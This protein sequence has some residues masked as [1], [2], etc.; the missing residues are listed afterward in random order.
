MACG[1]SFTIATA[2]RA[3][4]AP[5]AEH[6]VIVIWDGLR[7]DSVNEHDTP[8]LFKLAA[9]GTTFTN[10]HCVY[11]SSTEVNG[12]ALATG[13]YPHSTGI[14][15][16]SEF[17]PDIDPLKPF[18]TESEAAVRNG[19]EL[20]RGHYLGL[21]TVAE[22]IQ[23]NGGRTVVAGTKPVAL[24]ADRSERSEGSMSPMLYQGRTLPR[25]L[26]TMLAKSYGE[27]PKAAN[28]KVAAN[29]AADAWTTRSLTESL[30]A[31]GVPQ[32]SVLWLSEPDYAQHGSGPNSAVARDALK[33][34]DQ[35]LARVLEA[36]D[37][38][39]ARETTAVFVVS[40]HGFSTIG[41]SIDTAALLNDAG[42]HAF[43]TLPESPVT[44]S[45]VVVA[46]GG[47]VGLYVV[48]RDKRTIQRLVDFFEQSDFAGVIF[49]RFTIEG[50]FPLSAAE[51]DTPAAPDIVVALRWSAD[52]SKTGLPGMIACDSSK[53][54]V[55]QGMHATLSRFDM[56]NTL[57]A[58]G[59]GIRSRYKDEL[60][61]GNADVAPTVLALLG[62]TP[63]AEMDGRPLDEALAQRAAPAESPVIETLKATHRGDKTEW[64]QYLRRTKLGRQIYLDEGNGEATPVEKR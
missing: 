23:R 4:E 37:R 30:W 56:H 45:V 5:R 42:F 26:A 24:L 39:K 62:I 61:S 11:V 3:A 33:S 32:F 50:T 64:N 38:A 25:S 47:T 27:F 17:R 49:C 29:R 43:H 1:V 14:M 52:K 40:D 54:V 21:P 44:G 13:G 9:G 58:A 19:D 18:N 2:A 34:S 59:A 31:A 22:I 53:L 8:I 7:P 20:T 36:L 57:I 6:V 63:S 48:G 51:I 15:A 60:P 28:S 10:H 12:A 16:N 55:G 35:N 46:N 41:R